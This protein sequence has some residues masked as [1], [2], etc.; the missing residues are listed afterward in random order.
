MGRLDMLQVDMEENHRHSGESRNDAQNQ[1][2]ADLPLPFFSDN[3]DKLQVDA[4]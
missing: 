2:W 1:R 4:A 3:P